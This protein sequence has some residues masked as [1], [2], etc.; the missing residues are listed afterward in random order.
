MPHVAA[1]E[2]LTVGSEQAAE[3][4]AAAAET[5]SEQ[6]RTAGEIQGAIAEKLASNVERVV[7]EVSRLVERIDHI[8]V[9]S[10]LLT[11][12]VDDARE[13]VSALAAA[14]E[15]A[16]IADAGRQE[17]VHQAASSLDKLLA[18]L[19]GLAAFEHIETSAR[20]LGPI[21]DSTG[22]AIA[23]LGARMSGQAEAFGELVSQARADATAM[24][25]ARRTL[26]SDLSESTLA[27]HKLQDTLAQVADSV[28]RRLGDA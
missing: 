15:E 20:R 28:V 24:S 19:S 16:A 22:D 27:L 25:E 6:V 1:T 5:M 4:L 9:P 7:G 3:R 21:V 23:S 11:R 13:R 14:L 10:D 8:E 18:R 17:A 26:Q 2:R 12:Q